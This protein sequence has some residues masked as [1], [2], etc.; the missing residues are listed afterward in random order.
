MLLHYALANKEA[1]AHPGETAVV[2]VSAAMEALEDLR[3]VAGGYADALVGHVDERLAVALVYSDAHLAAIRAVLDGVLDEILED[4]TDAAR[5][6][7]ADDRRV[8]DDRDR[9]ALVAV[10]AGDLAGELDQVHRL[11]LADELSLLQARRRSFASEA[12]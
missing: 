12:P 5:V 4:L 3:E 10:A 11:A 1:E 8:G 2:H 7:G 6:V 9:V